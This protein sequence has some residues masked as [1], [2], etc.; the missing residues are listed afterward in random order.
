MLPFSP[1]GDLPDPGIEPASPAW[2]ADSLPLN[3]QG[4]PSCAERRGNV[5]SEDLEHLG[6]NLQGVPWWLTAWARHAAGEPSR[7]WVLKATLR[8]L[9]FILQAVQKYYRVLSR[10][11]KISLLVLPSTSPL[12]SIQS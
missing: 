12:R 11:L 5:L 1:P 8:S 4:G 7:G 3:H 9:G 6:F 2:Q 10:G